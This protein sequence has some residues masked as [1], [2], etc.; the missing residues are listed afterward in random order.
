MLITV[1][2]QVS[3]KYQVVIPKEVRDALALQ[4]RATL[5]FLIEGDTVILCPRPFSFTKMLRGLHRAVWTDPDGWLETERSA[6]E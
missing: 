5:L 4:P 3:T 6:W 2:A 1:P